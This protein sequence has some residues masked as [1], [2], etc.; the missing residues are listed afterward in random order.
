MINLKNEKTTRS[1]LSVTQHFLFK[2]EGNM[3]GSVSKRILLK[4]E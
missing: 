3:P 4:N 1:I 2:D